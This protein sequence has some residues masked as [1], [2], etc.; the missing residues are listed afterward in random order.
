M[1]ASVFG[2][3]FQAYLSISIC[4]SRGKKVIEESLRT[5]HFFKRVCLFVYDTLFEWRVMWNDFD[6][7]N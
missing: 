1:V 7:E 4:W 6:E 3:C 2:G 5:K